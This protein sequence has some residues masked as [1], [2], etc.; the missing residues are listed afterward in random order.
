VSIVEPFDLEPGAS[1]T[2]RLPPTPNIDDDGWFM[3]T[4]SSYVAATSQF[5]CD[6]GVGG[7]G[8]IPRAGEDLPAGVDVVVTED[9]TPAL[10]F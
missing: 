10:D 3:V 1:T 4:V 8:P 6:I 9:G 5:I 2:L 7:P